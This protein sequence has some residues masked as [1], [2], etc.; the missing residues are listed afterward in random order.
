MK[1]WT[2]HLSLLTYCYTHTNTAAT[3]NLTHVCCDSPYVVADYYGTY[4]DIYIV[5]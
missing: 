1:L 3:L 4:S 2:P 5:Y